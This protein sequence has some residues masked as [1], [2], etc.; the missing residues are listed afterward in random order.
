MSGYVYG[1]HEFHDLQEESK[2]LFALCFFVL[3]SE[4][5]RAVGGGQ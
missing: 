2:P 4:D 5:G 3:G 1:L